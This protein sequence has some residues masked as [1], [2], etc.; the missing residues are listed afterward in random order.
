MAGECIS[1]YP[2]GEHGHLDEWCC[3]PSNLL[4]LLT[5]EKTQI[6]TTIRNNPVI[7]ST[8]KVWR[9]LV[10]YT[11]RRGFTSSLIPI[12]GKKKLS[13]PGIRNLIFDVWYRKGIKVIGNLYLENSLMSL[14]DSNTVR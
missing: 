4:S 12:I 5:G 10:A 2:K 9:E 6:T 13:P 7:Y 14:S 11:R 8:I 1:E 3:T